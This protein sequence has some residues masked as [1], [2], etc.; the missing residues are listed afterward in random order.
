MYFPKTA[1]T[2]FDVGD[3]VYFTGTA[4][5]VS[6]HAGDAAEVLGVCRKAVISSDSD[7]TA[8]T[9]IPIEVVVEKMVEWTFL[10]ASLV[11]ADVGKYVDISTS[12]AGTID[13][14]TSADDIMLVTGVI[15]ATEGRGVFSKTVDARGD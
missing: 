12:D 15:S 7:Y 9:L 5:R 4:G 14:S 6:P 3:A 8:N 1:S 11:A 13:R 2:V 10:T